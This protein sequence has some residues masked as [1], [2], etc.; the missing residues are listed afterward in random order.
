MGGGGLRK[1]AS[2][3]P[4]PNVVYPGVVPKTDSQGR[5]HCCR[6]ARRVGQTLV[7]GSLRNPTFGKS[8]LSV[9]KVPGPA[10]R[11]D[12]KTCPLSG[13]RLAS[14]NDRDEG[15]TLPL[16]FISPRT[17]TEQ[18]TLLSFLSLARFAHVSIAS[19]LFSTS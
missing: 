11:T 13:N 15:A 3:A 6:N 14:S 7:V 9:S 5:L 12:R 16:H 1:R 17:S 8:S 10:V 2:T 4:R 19:A 18:P